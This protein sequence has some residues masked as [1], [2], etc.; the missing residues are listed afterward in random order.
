MDIDLPI[1]GDNLPEGEAFP[2]TSQRHPND[3]EVEES[4]S[5]VVAPARRKKRA[6]RTIPLDMT[7]ELR[8]KDLADWNA[9][10]LQNMKEAARLKNQYR[11]TQVA[12]KNAEYYVWGAGIGGIGARLPS[13]TVPSPFDRFIGDSFFELFTGVSRKGPAGTKRDRDS[14]IDDATQEESRRV[15]QRTNEPEDEIGR[16]Q[17]DEGMFLPGGDDVELPREAP[18]ALDD[19]QVFSAMP[20]NITASLRGSSVVPRSARVGILDSA[21]APSSLTGLHGRRGSR[22]IS[23]SP[24]HGRGQ[25]GG[26]DALRSFEEGDDE[27]GNLGGYDFGTPGFSSDMSAATSAPVT[28]RVREALS[29]ESE[30]FLDFVADAIHEK[31]NRAQANLMHMSDVLQVDA[32]ADTDEVLF[33]ELLPPVEDSRMVASQA[34]LMTLTLGTKGLLDVRQDGAFKEVSLNLTEKAKAARGEG[35]AQ[36]N[37]E[38]M[39]GDGEERDEYQG[40]GQFEEQFAAERGD[41]DED[42][43]GAEVNSLYED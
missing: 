34:F 28:V 4:S 42:D 32:A 7:M 10:Y 22:M 1:L 11:L 27:Y 21:G 15:R 40:G 13:I 2:V 24:L 35:P 16:G 3:H 8:N 36:G 23:A 14:G 41:S 12:K 9:N 5:T 43:E 33:E 18:S 20:W 25:P 17:E 37:I 19:Q 39:E 38:E 31:R 30:N 29:A 6:A 26:L